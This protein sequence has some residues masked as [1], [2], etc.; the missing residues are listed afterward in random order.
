MEQAIKFAEREKGLKV[1]P[2][3]RSPIGSPQPEMRTSRT[4]LQRAMLTLQVDV[5][6]ARVRE[7]LGDAHV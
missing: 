5:C 6:H 3:C 4:G 2:V 7:E 1:D